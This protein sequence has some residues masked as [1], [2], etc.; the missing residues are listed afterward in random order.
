VLLNMSDFHTKESIE[1]D[2]SVPLGTI[3][4]LIKKKRFPSPDYENSG[5]S[6]WHRLT[7]TQ[8]LTTYNKVQSAKTKYTLDYD[9]QRGQHLVRARRFVEKNNI[10]SPFEYREMQKEKGSSLAPTPSTLFCY[11]ITFEELVIAD[12]VPSKSCMQIV[13]NLREKRTVKELAMIVD[14]N[15]RT[16]YRKLK[17][18]REAGYAIKSDSS[19]VWL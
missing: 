1:N 6:Y 13:N 3:N 19:G 4:N 17:V 11:S 2:F 7:L 15:E 5:V 14:C 8:F 9:K 16:V 18:L 12:F 10:R